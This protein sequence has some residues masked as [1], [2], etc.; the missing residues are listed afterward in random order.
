MKQLTVF[1]V[2]A[3]I[4]VAGCNGNPSGPS[5]GTLT[6]TTFTVPL[7]PA[8]EVPPV[9]NAE[10]GAT[11][12]A[13]IVLRITRNAGGTA[14]SATADF[15][16]NVADF[17]AGS[18]I[19]MAHIHPGAAGSN[20]GILVDTGLASGQLALTGGAGSVSRNGVNVAADQAVAIVS[21]PAGY[22]FNV[23]SAMNPSGVLRGQLSGGGSSA[24]T[25]DSEP[26][27]Y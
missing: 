23:H 24:T 26:V 21:N 20:G 7:S 10:A 16:I 18:T 8:N 17:P 25:G 22:Y 3:G 2:A 15:Q 6:P 27:P 9:S 11:G 1:I 13:T 5:D 12:S 14:T 4:G 19:T